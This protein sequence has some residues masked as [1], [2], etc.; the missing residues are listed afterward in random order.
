MLNLRIHELV[1][2]DI[3]ALTFRANHD[4]STAANRLFAA[5]GIEP[6]QPKPVWVAEEH[7]DRFRFI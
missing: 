3:N 7:N 2:N 4:A 1:T 5:I 6:K